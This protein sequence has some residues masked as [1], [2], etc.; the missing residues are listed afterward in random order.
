MTSDVRRK[1]VVHP[2]A[3]PAG[4]CGARIDMNA[5]LLMNPGQSLPVAERLCVIR[6]DAVEGSP[7]GRQEDSEDP[8]PDWPQEPT[9]G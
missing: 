2:L 8:P 9:Y 3:G 5:A 1:T 6:R 4:G 7:Y